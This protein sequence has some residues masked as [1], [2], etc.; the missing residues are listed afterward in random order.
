MG[1]FPSSSHHIRE[2][3]NVASVNQKKTI[4][5]TENY[6][7]K[8]T[9][10]QTKANAERT[11]EIVQ[12]LSSTTDATISLRDILTLDDVVITVLKRYDCDL[13]EAAKTA[14]AREIDAYLFSTL[15]NVA[16]LHAQ[17]IVHSDLKLENIVVSKK[18]KT[19]KICDLDSAI[20]NF[21]QRI[22]NFNGGSK[23]HVPHAK[24]LHALENN[25]RLNQFER[26]SQLDIF[27]IGFS[28][29]RILS[30]TSRQNR[31]FFRDIA[32]LFRFFSQHIILRKNRR[33]L[34]L[35]HILMVANIHNTQLPHYFSRIKCDCQHRSEYDDCDVCKFHI[36]KMKRNKNIHSDKME[37]TN[38][39]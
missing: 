7:V 33:L 13:F 25:R 26:Y 35:V 15:F 11:A 2:F 22:N 28:V 6:F 21:D 23:F 20:V 38:I 36:K 29:G 1:S 10:H 30:L 34:R 3:D 24:I 17:G 18:L 27:A 31:A 16:N 14:S 12:H 39:M 37:H 4:V 19:T 8:V 9:K 5:N 32:F